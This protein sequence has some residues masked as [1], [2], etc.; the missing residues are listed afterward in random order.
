M[1]HKALNLASSLLV[2]DSFKDPWY[3]HLIPIYP[4]TCLMFQTG[5]FFKHSTTFPVFCFHSHNLFE[6]CLMFVQFWV[7]HIFTI[8]NWVKEHKATKL[9]TCQKE[10]ANDRILFYLASWLFWKRISFLFR[11]HKAKNTMTLSSTTFCYLEAVSWTEGKTKTSRT[12]GDLRHTHEETQKHHQL[13]VQG[14]KKDS[15]DAVSQRLWCWECN[16]A[17]IA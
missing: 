3:H 4:F 13:L 9:H 15:N 6:M 8:I 11:R 16:F 10:L 17:V 1:Y 12:A 14:E 2:N 7:K 5:I